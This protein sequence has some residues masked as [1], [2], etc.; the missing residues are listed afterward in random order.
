MATTFLLVAGGTGGHVFPALALREELIA[1]GHDVHVATDH[2]VSAFVDDVDAGRLHSVRAATVSAHPLRLA[3]S[4]V[5]LARGVME[6][7]RLLNRLRPGA[8]VGFGGYPSVPPVLAAK[9]LGVPAAVHEQNAVLGRANRLLVRLGA[10]LATGMPNPSGGERAS[11]AVHVG[12]PVRQAIV[13]AAATRY[14]PPGADDRIHLLVFGGSQG[15]R[16]FSNLLPAAVAELEPALRARLD[17]V[18]QC[19]P[20]DM[21][22]TERAYSDIGVHAKL[23]PFFK[24]M[25]RHLAAAHLVIARAGA[26]TVAE[27]SVV[28]RPAILVPYPHA[29]DHDQA[30][31]ALSFS[32]AGGGWMYR[33][34]ELTAEMLAERM[35][36]LFTGSDQLHAA[37]QAARQQGRTDAVARLADLVEK[38]AG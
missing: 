23:A 30:A 38:V 18:Q 11:K 29:L 14:D 7:R 20:E 36:K 34:A 5:V 28:G 9:L 8:V 2:R 27:L 19:R 1:R 35:K 3:G 6:S 37:A 13:D 16:V 33:E 4:L 15:A 32:Q 24:D 31:N 12:N 10:T 22:R 17:I 26:S 21:E 25:P